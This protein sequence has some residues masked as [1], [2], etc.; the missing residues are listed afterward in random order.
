MS[1]DGGETHKSYQLE[2]HHSALHLIQNIRDEAHRFAISAH[3]RRREKSS[4]Y[5]NL[6]DVPGIGPKR[7][8]QL[9]QHFGGLRG[10]QQATVEELMH[11]QGISG[12]LARIIFEYFH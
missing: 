8:K 9:L 1:H 6:N 7:K 4:R 3:R 10:L 12:S 2:H 5:S 11:V